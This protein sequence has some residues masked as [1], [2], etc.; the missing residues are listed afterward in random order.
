M[1]I[2]GMILKEDILESVNKGTKMFNL[3][4]STSITTAVAGYNVSQVTCLVLSNYTHS[5]TQSCTC[6]HIL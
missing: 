5:Y 3:F 1:I 2:L 4:S 6:V